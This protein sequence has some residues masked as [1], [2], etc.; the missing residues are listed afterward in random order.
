MNLSTLLKIAVRLLILVA[1]FVG[2]AGFVYVLGLWLVPFTDAADKAILEACNPDTYAPGL[3]QFFRALTDYTNFL[4]VATLLSWQVAMLFYRLLPKLKSVWVALL[5]I[6]TLAVA[7]MAILGKIWPN[8]TY[9]GVNVLLVLMILAGYGGMTWLFWK[10]DDRAMRRFSWVL[11]LMFLSGLLTGLQATRRIKDAV[12]R[13]RPLNDANKPWNEQVRI[14]PDEVLRGRNSYPSGH[15]TGTFALLTPLFW[16]VRRRRLRAGLLS[17][18]ILQGVSR[19]YTAAHFPFCCLMGGVLG[20]SV[21]TLIFFTLGGPSLWQDTGPSPNT[22]E[23]PPPS[24][25]P[26]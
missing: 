6:E 1:G 20:S 21:G 8:E 12:A 18:G 26:A 2:I 24:S 19:V 25:Q 23:A 13:P 10:L 14:I 9:T 11:W 15:T 16:Y 5:G 3:D 17:W 7:V 22:E 4:I